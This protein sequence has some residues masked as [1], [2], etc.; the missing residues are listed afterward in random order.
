MPAMSAPNGRNFA[1]MARCRE[2]IV[3]RGADGSPPDRRLA[4]PLVAGDEEQDPVAARDRLLE[5]PVDRSPGA[6]QGQSM[7][8]DNSVRL[9]QPTAQPPVPAAVE[10]RADRRLLLGSSCARQA[11]ALDGVWADFGVRIECCRLGIIPGARERPDCR[12]YASPESRF[13]RAERA[14]GPLPPWAAGHRRRRSPPFRP[15]SGLLR[16]PNPRRCRTCSR[17]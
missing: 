7:E 11:D 8:V 5:R 17:P 4:R 12:C 2:P 10:G 3:D 15:R 9:E 13:F 16:G 1:G 6:I 14:H